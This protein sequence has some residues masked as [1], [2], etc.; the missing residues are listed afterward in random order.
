MNSNNGAPHMTNGL[1]KSIPFKKNQI[2][3]AFSSR[4]DF[5]MF[6]FKTFFD[7]YLENHF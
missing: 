2:L 5:K 6:N 3:D 7:F 4:I 1:P